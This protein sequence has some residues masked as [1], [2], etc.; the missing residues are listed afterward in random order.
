MSFL[1][2]LII[3]A[4]I[5]FVLMLILRILNKGPRFN[6]EGEG[7]LVCY[8]DKVIVLLVLPY[9][10]IVIYSSI[11]AT[12]FE[13]WLILHGLLIGALILASIIKNKSSNLVILGLG[14]SMPVV[15]IFLSLLINGPMP[16]TQDEGRF[17]GYAY[18]I[19]QDGKWESYTYS[20]NPYYQ[21]FNIVPYFK[22][23]ISMITGLDMLYLVHPL[24][25][26]VVTSLVSLSIYITLKNLIGMQGMKLGILGPILFCSTPSISTLGFIPQVLAVALYL[27][28]LTVISSVT[29]GKSAYKKRFVLIILISFIGIMTH[30]IYPMLLLSTLIPLS[31]AFGNNVERASKVH[32]FRSV[33]RIVALLTLVYWTYTLVLDLLVTTGKVWTQSLIEIIT[34]E[35]VPFGK[36]KEVWYFMG[37]SELAYSW[38][39][40]LA[41]AAAY[42]STEMLLGLKGSTKVKEAFR[43]IRRDPL[44]CLGITGIGILGVAFISR[45][46]PWG[47]ARYSYSFYILLIPASVM[48]IGKIGKK[49]RVINTTLLVL[50]VTTASF[51]AVQD[52]M[53]SPDIH[54]VMMVANKRTWAVAESLAP[55][56]SLDTEY[57]VDPRVNVPFGALTIKSTPTLYYSELETSYKGT[58]IILNHDKQGETWASY[59]LE[60][61]VVQGIKNN[62]Y[63]NVY[64]DGLYRAY[65]I[66]LST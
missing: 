29:S 35:V 14:L 63:N 27:T 4:I 17:T 33:I 57:H 52:P 49:N 10:F 36:G 20:E 46:S 44:V 42:I 22:A 32:L 37:P 51:Y 7:V 66:S 43:N 45:A 38:T 26:L 50:I 40:L 64:T 54:K 23:T 65:Y 24:T 15:T 31:F 19:I 9:M 55:Y 53:F 18:T 34:G 25:V 30:A 3:F 21:L 2:A 39:L 12:R 60:D 41:F 11:A 28:A 8:L 56:A 48:I 47:F 58:L 6:K 16:I 59:W 13:F 1:T 61:T 5:Q 62:R